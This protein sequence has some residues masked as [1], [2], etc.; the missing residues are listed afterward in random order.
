MRIVVATGIDRMSQYFATTLVRRF[1]E[2]VAGAIFQRPPSGVIQRRKKLTLRRG[3]RYA[4]KHGFSPVRIWRDRRFARMLRLE[5]PDAAA[6][7]RRMFPADDEALRECTG[8]VWTTYDIHQSETVE[9][10]QRLRD[11]SAHH[12]N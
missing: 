6:T 11:Q 8:R 7:R 3:L 5:L 10:I 1:G 2:Q 9:A 4:A 12:A